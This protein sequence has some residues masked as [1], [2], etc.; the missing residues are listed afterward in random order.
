MGVGTFALASGLVVLRTRIF[1][2]WLGW[3]IFALGIVSFAPAVGFFAAFPVF[4]WIVIV[5]VILFRRGDAPVPPV[6]PAAPATV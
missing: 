5:S 4:G 2:L 6:P 1:P 3:V